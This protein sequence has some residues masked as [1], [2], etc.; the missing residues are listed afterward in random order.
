MSLALVLKADNT[1]ERLE[2]ISLKTLQGAV[3][4]WV[5]ALT[6][7]DFTMWVNEEGKLI[8]GMEPNV[9]AT[10]M[11]IDEFNYQDVILGNVVFT[12]GADEE[13]ETLPLDEKVMVLI[14]QLAS[15]YA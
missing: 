3:G 11:F 2:E 6:F 4:G 10:S 14:E 8:D 13:G 5:Q 15:K 9:L 1:T 12:G 7:Q